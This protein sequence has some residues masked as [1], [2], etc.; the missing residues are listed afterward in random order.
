[1]DSRDIPE[2]VPELDVGGGV[3][4]SFVYALGEIDFRYPSLGLEK[5]VAQVMGRTGPAHVTE[6]RAVR[7]VISKPENR[8]LA[9][10]LCWILTIQGLETYIVV[11]QDPADLDLLI[12]AIQEPAY[13][14]DEQEAREPGRRPA[15][16]DVVIGVMQG[17]APPQ[18]CNGLAVPVVVFDQLYSFDRAGLVKSIPPPGPMAHADEA[19]FRETAGSFFD[20]IMR[21]AD[22]AGATDEHRALNYLAVRYPRIYTT[23]TEEQDRNATLAG[24]DARP[25]TLSGVRRIVEVV[26]SFRHRETDVTSKY[27]ARVDV[28][29]EHPFLMTPLSPYYDLR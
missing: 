7:E 26:F 14:D 25:S 20:Q 1:M 22:N 17:I 19:R 8:Y 3:S 9:R 11:P 13:D 16:V 24:I 12:A 29:D 18:M 4:P 27:M 6:R 21:M 15:H 2:P 10:G 23:V 28:E 5:E